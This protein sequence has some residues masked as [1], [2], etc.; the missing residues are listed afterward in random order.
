VAGTFP[1]VNLLREV[2]K[3]NE[4]VS[5]GLIEGVT[6]LEAVAGALLSSATCIW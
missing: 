6:V 2:S 3:I 4:Q 1:A 5:V